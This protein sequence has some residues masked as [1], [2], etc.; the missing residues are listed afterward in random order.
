MTNKEAKVCYDINDIY[1][2]D[3]F[4]PHCERKD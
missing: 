2:N 3:T 4:L 1:T